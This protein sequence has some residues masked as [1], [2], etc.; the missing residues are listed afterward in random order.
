MHASWE[1]DT[2][3]CIIRVFCSMPG[4]KQAEFFITLETFVYFVSCAIDAMPVNGTVVHPM[5]A[6]I[7][8]S[9]PRP[10]PSDACNFCST[11]LNSVNIP[12]SNTH[13]IFSSIELDRLGLLAAAGAAT[14]PSVLCPPRVLTQSRRSGWVVSCLGTDGLILIACRRSHYRVR[15]THLPIT[16]VDGSLPRKSFFHQKIVLHTTTSRKLNYSYYILYNTICIH[17]LFLFG[18]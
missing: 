8:R 13:G 17:R 12:V 11:T 1:E 4:S 15:M 2:V 18:L 9:L 3:F 6:G 14:C 7:F 16:T 10:L 5:A